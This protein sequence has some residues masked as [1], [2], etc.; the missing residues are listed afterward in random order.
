MGS[1]QDNSAGST[2]GEIDA[3]AS[4]RRVH[5]SGGQSHREILGSGEGSERT[6]GGSLAS[7]VESVPTLDL[8]T[9]A[10][11]VRFFPME[12]LR[13]PRL[14]PFANTYSRLWIRILDY[15]NT[16]FVQTRKNFSI[17]FKKRGLRETRNPVLNLLA[18]N[19]FRLSVAKPGF[20]SI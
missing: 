5:F 19:A 1:S 20:K 3:E 15:D 10:F 7:R 9:V 11:H 18:E 4:C 12:G 2:G 8:L 13:C 6:G 14:A 17:F 16:G